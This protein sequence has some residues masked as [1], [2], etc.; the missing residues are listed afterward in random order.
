MELAWEEN[1]EFRGCL[2]RCIALE[3]SSLCV[4]EVRSNVGGARLRGEL[5][6]ASS[7]SDTHVAPELDGRT[8]LAES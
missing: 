5:R 3:G 8:E 4:V 2:D 1:S 7:E 6:T